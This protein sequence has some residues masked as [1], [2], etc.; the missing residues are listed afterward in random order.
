MKW[1]L[2]LAALALTAPAAPAMAQETDRAAIAEQQQAMS[3]LSWMFGAWR[4]PGSGFTRAG[5]YQVTQTERI[6]PFLD[7]TL[8]VIEGKG[9]QPDGSVGFNAFAVISY[10]TATKTYSMRSYAL[11]H[12]GDFPL[13]LTDH[14]YTW[15]IPAGP[16]AV[17]RYTMTLKD[18]TWN[19]VGDYVAG[20]Q[21]P[22]R[23]FEMNLQRVGNTDW[24]L[25]GSIAPK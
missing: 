12:Y 6:G 8:I 21:P 1:F 2:F 23:I 20:G 7:G 18:G 10:D 15:E 19:E 5:P 22:R 11:G 24:P 16:G 17:I 14:G 25:A 13:T 3:K 4:G 9:Y